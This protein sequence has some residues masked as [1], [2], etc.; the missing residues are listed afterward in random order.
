MVQEIIEK[1]KLA[2]DS[3]YPDIE[4]PYSFRDGENVMNNSI[5]EQNELY[6]KYSKKWQHRVKEGWYG[7]GGLGNPTP[8]VWYNVI[9]EMLTYIEKEC[10]DLVI[11]QIKIKWGILC[12]YVDGITPEINQEIRILTNVLRDKKLIY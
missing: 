11:R 5:Q 4:N 3:Y 9:D 6:E 10:P 2:P 8:P 7:F 12:M 1:Y